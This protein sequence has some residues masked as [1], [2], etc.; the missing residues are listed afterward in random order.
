MQ[1]PDLS[2]G[3]S[4]GGLKWV[5]IGVVVLAAAVGLYLAVRKK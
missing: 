4:G 5:V 3:P 1:M 2:A